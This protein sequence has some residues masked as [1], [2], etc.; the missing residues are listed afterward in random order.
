VKSLYTRFFRGHAQ[1]LEKAHEERCLAVHVEHARKAD[2]QLGSPGHQ[3][4][5]ALDRPPLED[6][7]RGHLRQWVGDR[8]DIHR[9]K[10]LAGGDFN[11]V[12]MGLLDRIETALDLAH[13][14]HILDRPFFAGRDDQALFAFVQRNL[15]FALGRC[16]FDRFARGLAGIAR[17]SHIRWRVHRIVT[18]LDAGGMLRLRSRLIHVTGEIDMHAVFVRRLVR[19]GLDVDEGPQALVLAE[20]AAGGLVAGGAKFDLPHLVEPDEGGFETLL[21]PQPLGFE[22]ASDRTALPAMLVYDDFG[23]QPGAHEA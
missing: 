9:A 23:I 21:R 8:C 7:Q 17:R 6:V 1:R 19:A 18:E 4:A 13:V 12:G 22:G 5:A 3:F 10:D 15:G 2:A 14:G 16:P 20:I 11:Q